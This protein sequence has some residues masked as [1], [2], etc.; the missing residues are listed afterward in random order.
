[1]VD[2][3]PPPPPQYHHRHYHQFAILDFFSMKRIHSPNSSFNHHEIV[4]Q[5]FY[6]HTPDSQQQCC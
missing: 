2:D 5:S 1:M 4:R 3:L 6:N